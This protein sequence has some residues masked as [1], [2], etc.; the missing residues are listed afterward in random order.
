LL[1]WLRLVTTVSAFQ[2][3]LADDFAVIVALVWKHCWLLWP[4]ALCVQRRSVGICLH[5]DA[6]KLFCLVV[7]HYKA[8]LICCTVVK[9]I[10]FHRLVLIC[11]ELVSGI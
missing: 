5:A 3:T 9:R 10:A 7:R 1:W 6:M 11:I 4:F 2:L 8:H